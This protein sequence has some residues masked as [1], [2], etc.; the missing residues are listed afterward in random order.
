MA[1][2][3]TL[4]L[5]TEQTVSFYNTTGLI[6]KDKNIYFSPKLR[7]PTNTPLLVKDGWLKTFKSECPSPTDYTDISISSWS[8]QDRNLKV[9]GNID[10]FR[11]VSEFGTALNY[12]ILTRDVY[13]AEETFKRY[14]YG[15]FITAVR[16]AGKGSVDLTL[17]PDDFTNV[18]FL[19]N[20]DLLPRSPLPPYDPFNDK[21]KNCYVERQHYDRVV[22]ENVTKTLNI[23]MDDGDEYEAED[24]NIML[25]DITLYYYPADPSILEK[26]LTNL[27]LVN[28]VLREGSSNPFFAYQEFD[29]DDFYVEDDCLVIQLHEKED[30]PLSMQTAPT[31]VEAGLILSYSEEE[32]IETNLDI[33][34]KIEEQ[35]NFKRLVKDYH[36]QLNYGNMLTDEEI[37]LYK[38]TDWANLTNAQKQKAIDLSLAFLHI[39]TANPEIFYGDGVVDGGTPA[40]S[41]VTHYYSK[42]PEGDVNDYLMSVEIPICI[43]PKELNRQKENLKTLFSKYRVYNGTSF[44]KNG[45]IEFVNDTNLMLNNIFSTVIKP[46][47]I[48]SYIVRESSLYNKVTFGVSSGTEMLTL[49][50]TNYKDLVLIPALKGVSVADEQLA[51][52][53]IMGNI[54]SG[55]SYVY[56]CYFDD[57]NFNYVVHQKII[58]GAD[59]VLGSYYYVGLITN[60][61]KTS[62]TLDLSTRSIPN[63]KTEYFDTLLTFSPY[64]F[65]S[66]S[67]LGRLENNFNKLNYYE[68]TTISCELT[69]VATDFVNYSF[70]PTYTIGGMEL[71]YYSEGFEQTFSNEYTFASDHLAEYILAQGS[72]MKA[73]Y[74]ITD[75]NNAYTQI[76]DLV[77]GGGDR[78]S[79]TWKGYSQGGAGGGAMG[80]LIQTYQESLQH[81][82]NAISHKQDMENLSASQTSKLAD[83]G[84][85]PD[86]FKQVGTNLTIDMS[87]NEYG[88]YLNHYKIDEV[89][90]NSI[91]KYL[92]RFGYYVNIYSDLK[93]NNRVGWNYIKLISFDYEL[94][95]TSEQ[96]ENIRQIF[97][98]GVTLL[99][100]KS[101]MTNGH[102]YESSI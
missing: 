31:L 54:S 5:K 13:S 89:S 28:L 42:M 37:R 11:L 78:L 55:D 98:N 9:R 84:V 60:N 81:I 32:Y 24:Y 93:V 22:K 40:T 33:F 66:I 69:V 46:Y 17:E 79:A 2:G 83:M 80:G 53:R 16:Q 27:E 18:F 87:I 56:Y 25:W 41:Y 75:R 85:K 73:Q 91:C 48:T 38:T 39:N 97:F 67:V 76:R 10:D 51:L 14:F 45:V 92:E 88:L 63:V 49:N 50:V 19:H 65:W 70:I 68:N 15:F 74:A 82:N 100:D 71:K 61:K 3:G 20:E 7:R 35:Y 30:S 26:P 34:S 64:D 4:P 102:N 43:V 6:E 12:M 90:Y 101:V 58:G 95:L 23:Y 86:S 77:K 94:P 99:H 36:R 52:S 47:I 21:M 1:E 62:F 44:L 29:I 72:Q 8:P 59:S 57:V 96:E